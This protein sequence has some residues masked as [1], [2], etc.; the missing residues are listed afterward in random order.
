MALM[1]AQ[2]EAAFAGSPERAAN[3]P[4]TNVPLYVKRMEVFDQQLEDSGL[5]MSSF[6]S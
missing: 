6:L 4:Q 2:A 1:Q 3:G 5:C